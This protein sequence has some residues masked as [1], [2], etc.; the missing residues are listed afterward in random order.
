MAQHRCALRIAITLTYVVA[1]VALASR[2]SAASAL[3]S[4][5]PS[6]QPVAAVEKSK[7]CADDS[8]SANDRSRDDTESRAKSARSDADKDSDEDNDEDHDEDNDSAAN[9]KANADADSEGASSSDDDRGEPSQADASQDSTGSHKG[10]DC[11]DDDDSQDDA[12]D[13]DPDESP[14]LLS[15]FDYYS[16]SEHNLTLTTTSI[17]TAPFQDFMVSLRR[18]WVQAR[19]MSEV[20][21]AEITTVAF[22]R[23]FSEQFGIGGS[24]GSARA[25]P[26][27]AEVAPAA[28]RSCCLS[29]SQ[30]WMTSA[31]PST[32][33]PA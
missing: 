6:T 15:Q 26:S 27:S 5:V 10:N 31:E 23:D 21:A 24:F 1:I 7:R 30:F 14:T 29:L 9:P 11:S 25:M 20:Q 22:S 3:V 28:A 16:D 32:A 8:E 13:V 17:A 19:S 4:S 18:D 12:A 33:T 2:A